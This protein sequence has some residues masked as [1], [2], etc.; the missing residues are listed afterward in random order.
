V[1]NIDI[2]WSSTMGF[3]GC[4]LIILAEK[5]LECEHTTPDLRL[6]GALA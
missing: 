3:A 2:T 1:L 4:G 6:S 5:D